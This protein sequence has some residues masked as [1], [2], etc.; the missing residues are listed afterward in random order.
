MTV[1]GCLCLCLVS[2]SVTGHG[3][4]KS[5]LDRQK[6]GSGLL[7]PRRSMAL[8]S[9]GDGGAREQAA[10]TLPSLPA[11]AALPGEQRVCAED[12]TVNGWQKTRNQHVRQNLPTAPRLLRT[13]STK[14]GGGGVAL[15]QQPHGAASPRGTLNKVVQQGGNPPPG[16]DLFSLHPQ[17]H[18]ASPSS[19]PTRLHP[20]RVALALLATGAAN[21]GT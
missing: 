7:A 16:G 12:Q 20:L 1:K 21:R 9:P 19:L 8:A 3:R 15:S 10:L 4:R 5:P 11:T 6:Q 17:G 18:L 2:H 13:L 14:T